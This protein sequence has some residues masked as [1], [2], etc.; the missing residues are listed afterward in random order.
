MVSSAGQSGGTVMDSGMTVDSSVQ[1][2]DPENTDSDPGIDL[3]A[4]WDNSSNEGS[5]GSDHTVRA[6]GFDSRAG[7]TEEISMDGE[8]AQATPFQFDRTTQRGPFPFRFVGASKHSVD[9]EENEGSRKRVFVEVDRSGHLHEQLQN[10][11]MHHAQRVRS[12]RKDLKAS[13]LIS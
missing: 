11:Q 10:E 2:L 1:L 4:M 5:D 12:L 6:G 8:D 7:G 13:S 9:P 3:N